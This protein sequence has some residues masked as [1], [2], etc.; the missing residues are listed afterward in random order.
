MKPLVARVTAMPRT[1]GNYPDETVA[2]H[3]EIRDS[4]SGNMIA[5]LDIPADAFLRMMGG[6]SEVPVQVEVG[7]EA[8]HRWGKPQTTHHWE[9]PAGEETPSRPHDVPDQDDKDLLRDTYLD[10]AL[11]AADMT[12]HEA[13]IG[14][15]K[16]YSFACSRT[17]RRTVTVSIWTY[18]E[19]LKPGCCKGCGRSLHGSLR[20]DC[21]TDN[22]T[23]D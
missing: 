12:R 6:R 8:A 21:G 3:M 19:P 4:M 14:P 7:V 22:S 16:D 1:R 2:Y 11:V 17:N 15:I 13:G 20:C 23:D 10:R 18:D 5:I 9:S